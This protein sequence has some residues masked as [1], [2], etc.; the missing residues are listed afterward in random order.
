MCR[1]FIKVIVWLGV[2]VLTGCAATNEEAARQ[3]QAEMDSYVGRSVD[4]LILARGVPTAA[5]PLSTGGRVLEYT[6]SK[7]RISGGH[8]Y[9]TYTPVY[10]PNSSGGGT[11]ISVPS[12]QSTPIHTSER[13]CR[14]TFQVSADNL[15][16]N[17]K[18]EGN[19]CRALARP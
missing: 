10:V 8:S 2:L 16:M 15:V 5:A 3:F 19:D 13:Y 1:T 17:W 4:E 11:W 12:P 18:A 6:K 14:L 7:T 9:T